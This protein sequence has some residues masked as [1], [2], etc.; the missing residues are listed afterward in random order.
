[1]R[2]VRNGTLLS[3]RFC[4]FLR[5]ATRG[6]SLCRSLLG[7]RL[8][9]H[10]ADD[11]F[12]RLRTLGVRSGGGLSRVGCG[13]VDCV[14]GCDGDGGVVGSRTCVAG[15]STPSILRCCILCC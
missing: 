7:S 1:M 8:I 9:Q 5:P 15:C 6:P 3:L 11:V 13:S 12:G 14:V 4:G 10:Q 2:A